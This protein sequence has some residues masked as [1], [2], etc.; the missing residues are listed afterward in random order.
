MPLKTENRIIGTIYAD[1]CI[2]KIIFQDMDVYFLLLIAG[3]LADAIEWFRISENLRG[4]NLPREE[5]LMGAISFVKGKSKTIQNIYKVIKKV[6]PTDCT[7]LLI[8][9][10]GVGKNYMAQFIHNQSKRKN[11]KFITVNCG[12]LPETLFESELFGYCKGAFTGAI[13]SKPGLFEEAEKGT[14]FFNEIANTSLALQA[15]LLEVMEY[16]ALRRLEET[17][18]K[19]IDVRIICATN[20]DLKAL[21]IEKKFRED[22]YHRLNALPINIPPLRERKVDIPIF[23]FYFVKE[24]AKEFK[25]PFMKLT[26]EVLK[27]LQNYPWSGNIRE[28]KN[29]MERAVLLGSG[30]E[31]RIDDID[32]NIVQYRDSIKEGKREHQ[33]EEIIKALRI[34]EGDIEKAAKKLY[35]TPRHLYRLLKK[36]NI[37]RRDYSK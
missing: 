34:T 17:K 26:S 32:P 24:Y 35:I 36:Y 3:P 10:T 16:K 31:I 33:K 4:G 29:V 2:A 8:G 30:P 12:A 18:S 21:V 13:K 28:L 14:I 37:K 19:K 23:A 15:K 11:Q 27:A 20:Q 6:A 22:L 1:S 9:E 7:L 5:I 25:K